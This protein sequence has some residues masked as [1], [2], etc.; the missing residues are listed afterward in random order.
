MKK[1][2]QKPSNKTLLDI[3]NN[4]YNRLIYLI[5]KPEVTYREQSVVVRDGQN[6]ECGGC[7]MQNRT[8]R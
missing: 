6:D 8:G 5:R 7:G 2:K 3:V 4:N 1:Q